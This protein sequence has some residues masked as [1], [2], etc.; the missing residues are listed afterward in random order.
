MKDFEDL[1]DRYAG[2]EI[3]VLGAGPSLDD[4][5]DGFFDDK[6]SITVNGSFLGIPNA[7]YFHFYHGVF[8]PWVIKLNPD[9]LGKCII[10]WPIGEI[11]EFKN[12]EW[13]Q[14]IKNEPIY[15]DR[16][17]GPSTKDD[18]KR[19]VSSIIKKERCEYR[20]NG[21]VAHLAI[22]IA[23]VLGAKKITVID[24]K[25]V[26]SKYKGHAQRGR[27]SEFYKEIPGYIYSLKEQTFDPYY[28][29]PLGISWLA[30]IFG[31]YGIEVRRF[32][33]GKGYEEIEVIK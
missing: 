28:I 14:K 29:I 32:Y 11:E 9:F 26:A 25:G 8:I 33:Y 1:R 12:E 20:M 30:G 3:W 24:C 23:A 2:K 6:I 27:M 18:F 17:P 22:E 31:K 7:T 5:P 16:P 10:A 15:M 4:F 21:T 13:W 19:V